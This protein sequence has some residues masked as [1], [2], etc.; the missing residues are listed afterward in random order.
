MEVKT[1]SPFCP[2]GLPNY[3]SVLLPAADV[4][5]NWKMTIDDENS[6]YVGGLPYDATEE[7]IRKA[8]DFYGRV[9]AVKVYLFHNINT[10]SLIYFVSR[11]FAWLLSLVNKRLF[12]GSFN[13]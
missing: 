2:S 12:D 11:V 1:Q 10:S 7:S 3:Y 8:F 6:V 4:N 9:V 5:W 13:C